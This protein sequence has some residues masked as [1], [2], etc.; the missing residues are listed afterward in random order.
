MNKL[1]D[2]NNDKNFNSMIQKPRSYILNNFLNKILDIPS[3]N[4]FNKSSIETPS[5]LAILAIV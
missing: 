4:Y 1:S 2:N 5:A 3:F